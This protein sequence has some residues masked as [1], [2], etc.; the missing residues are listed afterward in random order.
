M[1]KLVFKLADPETIRHLLKAE[2]ALSKAGVSFDRGITYDTDPHERWWHLD[3]SL[4]GASLE[5][6]PRGTNASDEEGQ[7]D[8]G[9]DGKE[10]RAEEGCRGL[11]CQ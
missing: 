3:W 4:E 5:F 11:L 1:A 7:E 2:R 10:V 9:S 8:K 6:H